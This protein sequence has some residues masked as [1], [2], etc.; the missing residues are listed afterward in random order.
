MLDEKILR[1]LENAANTPLHDFYLAHPL[2]LR[3]EVRGWELILEHRTGVDIFNPFYDI[4]REEILRIDAGIAEMYDSSFNHFNIVETDLSHLSTCRNILVI[5]REAQS[6]G[7]H[8]EMWD[9]LRCGR[10]IFVITNEF[11]NHPWVKYCI[12]KTKGQGFRTW[13]DFKLFL[14]NKYKKRVGDN[15]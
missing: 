4:H 15:A 13:G 6:I 7:T 14:I 10:S 1:T 2:Q 8:C 12:Q 9:S 5:L 11:L 3:H